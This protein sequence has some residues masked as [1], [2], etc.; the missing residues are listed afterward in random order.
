MSESVRLRGLLVADLVVGRAV[1]S[2]ADV[3]SALQRVWAD[4]GETGISID[5]E[6]A[7][8]ADLDPSVLRAVLDEA[9]RLIDDAGGDVLRALT[10][11]GGVDRSIHGALS[12]H[13]GSV[14]SLVELGVGARS[15]LRTTASDRYVDFAVTGEGGMGV[16][17]ITLDTELSRR[18]AFKMIRTDAGAQRSTPASPLDVATPSPDTPTSA[19][20][21]EL[22]A[23]FLQEAWITG[24]LE[25]PGVVPVYELGQTPQGIPYYT[26]RLV[27]GEGTLKDAIAAQAGASIDD[28][29]ALLEPYLKVCDT[30]R[31]AHRRGVVHRDLK[32][33]NVALGEFGEVVVLDW[34]LA[35]LE[36]ARDLDASGW[37]D[38]VHDFRGAVDLETRASLGTPGYMSPEA[39]LGKTADVDAASDVYSLGVILYEILTGSAPFEFQTFAEYLAMVRQDV[40]PPAERAPDVPD[41]L[42]AICTSAM[43]VDRDDRLRDVGD[44]ARAIRDWQIQSAVEKETEVRLEAARSALEAAASLDGD[45]RIRQVDRAAAALAQLGDKRP[46]DVEELVARVGRLRELGVRERERSTTRRVLMRTGVAVLLVAIVA[47]IVVAGILDE[48]RRDAE[49]ARDDAD[50]A[51]LELEAALD[52]ERRAKELADKRRAEAEEAARQVRALSLAGASSAVGAEDPMLALL[53]AREAV[54]LSEDPVTIQRLREAIGTSLE[55]ARLLPPAKGRTAGSGAGR[56]SLRTADTSRRSRRTGLRSISGTRTVPGWRRCDR[57]PRRPF[58]G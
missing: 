42:S 41:A 13:G 48:R 54:A 52:G 57:R 27:R 25:H 45:D 17:Y 14:S 56:G 29:L 49:D 1:A 20:F 40:V 50:E 4:G 53:L 47:A 37:Q 36:G 46:L 6:I 18:V 16:V 15:P 19:A 30:L 23:R 26:M 32:P 55:R 31:Y 34:G 9:D 58:G 12:Q 3:A 22:K 2:P 21:E 33:E 39:A 28:R 43:A 8:I 38:R 10:L 11:R 7:R 5:S 35:K 24:G 51:R 44:L